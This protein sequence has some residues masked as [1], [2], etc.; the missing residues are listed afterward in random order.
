[1][2]LPGIYKYFFIVLLKASLFSLP[3]GA[4]CITDS[5]PIRRRL[6]FFPIILSLLPYRLELD[7]IG[8]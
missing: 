6:A 2:A 1:M 7:L 4:M 3:V 5:G 8:C